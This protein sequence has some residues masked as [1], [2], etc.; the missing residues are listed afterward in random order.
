MAPNIL[1]DYLLVGLLCLTSAPAYAADTAWE[2]LGQGR[3]ARSL[4]RTAPN[5]GSAEAGHAAARAAFGE[6]GSTSLSQLAF[7]A[8]GA[9]VRPPTADS[10]WT[11]AMKIGGAAAAGG[12]L[13]F[14]VAGGPWGAAIGAAAGLAAGYH[15]SQGDRG[16]AVQLAL[17]AAGGIVGFAFGGPIGA[18]VGSVVGGMLGFLVGYF[19]DKGKK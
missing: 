2:S 1:R 17:T 11:K 6:A 18:L 7:H 15:W 4:S 12:L 19:M 8:E 13:G 14:F 5:A 10:G 3:R 16:G 9:P